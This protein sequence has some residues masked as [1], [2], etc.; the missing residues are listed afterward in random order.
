MKV[1]RAAIAATIA[2]A[3]SVL[4]A[5]SRAA[6][7][8]RLEQQRVEALRSGKDAAAFYATTYRGIDAL[9]Q[10]ETIE[11]VRARRA[12]PGYARVSDTS[13]EVHDNTA[14][15]TGIEGA[16]D[17]ELDL[18]L[19]IWTRVADTWT[20]AAAQTTWIG[21]RPNGPTLSGALP[22]PTDKLFEP[23]T[24]EEEAIWRSQ[25]ALMRSFSN[26]DPES[27]RMF[28][29]EQSLRMTT[30]GDSIPR[31][32]W[33]KTMAGRQR[34]PLAVVDEV[35]VAVYG[36]VGLVTL[37]GHEANPTRQSWVYLQEGGAW[38]LHLRWTT[39]IR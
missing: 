12:H 33:L 34:G 16:D 2:L 5:Q 10:Y 17:A 1:E 18:V 36:D 24:N 31:D 13:I 4:L 25:D 6:A 19:R 35:K 11:H 27:Y 9:G 32:E 20:I 14:I 21:D 39:L 7:V 30:K 23:A 3:S 38:K 15:L 37:R 26:A 22:N 29:T 8:S 28:S